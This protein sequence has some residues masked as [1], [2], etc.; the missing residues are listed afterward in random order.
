MSSGTG[1]GHNESSDQPAS[2]EVPPSAALAY[3]GEQLRS[4][5]EDQQRMLSA[6][7]SID[8][9]IGQLPEKVDLLRASQL[10]VLTP[11][12][13]SAIEKG[14]GLAGTVGRLVAGQIETASKL[15]RVLGIRAGLGAG[16]TAVLTSSPS[17]LPPLL[18]FFGGK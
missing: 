1:N 3:L 9:R 13:L 5:R 4:L 6:L 15:A 11:D 12:E 10:G 7:G 2:D 17:W 14:T 8:K 18:E 16:L